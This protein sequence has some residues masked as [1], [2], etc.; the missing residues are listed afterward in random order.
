MEAWQHECWVLSEQDL[1]AGQ[2][3]VRVLRPGTS[4][5]PL[6]S[7]GAQEVTAADED[8]LSLLAVLVRLGGASR[9]PR[10]RLPVAATSARAL[11]P[12]VQTLASATTDGFSLWWLREAQRVLQAAEANERPSSNVVPIRAAQVAPD[13]I[14]SHLCETRRSIARA[15][16]EGLLRPVGPGF[17]VMAVP[18]TNALFAL[19]D[20]S[21]VERRAQPAE[22]APAA[23]VS[24]Y[25]ASLFAEW[26]GM[27]LP[28]SAERAEIAASSSASGARSLSGGLYEWCEDEAPSATAG[29]GLPLPD[30]F[31]LHEEARRF[32]TGGQ[33]NRGDM[34]IAHPAGR[35][36]VIGLRLVRGAMTQRATSSLRAV[37]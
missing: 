17:E 32:I 10:P 34:V 22:G 28:T 30:R 33:A 27:R 13:P 18:V 25:E 14:F 37:S 9:A 8:E 29:L 1:G 20:P 2:R 21:H 31:G 26:V 36:P 19:M 24:W 16:V 35:Q 12:V 15:L 5:L 4:P 3:R 7:P 6:P 23:N 11:L